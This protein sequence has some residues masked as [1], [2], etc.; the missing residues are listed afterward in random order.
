MSIEKEG[1]Y[2][3]LK[4]ITSYIL[5]CDVCGEVGQVTSNFA[6]AVQYKKQEKWKS[7]KD[8]NGD[9]EDVCPNCQ[10]GKL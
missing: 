7:Q 8:S 5:I 6:D 2:H 3:K 9:W 4:S 10:S 1:M